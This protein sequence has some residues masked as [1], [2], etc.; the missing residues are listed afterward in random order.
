MDIKATKL[1]I[2]KAIAEIESEVLI[3]QILALLPKAKKKRVPNPEKE[4]F[5]AIAREPLPDYISVE[6]LK[7][8]QGYNIEKLNYFYKN[9]N[10]SIWEGENLMD[11]LNDM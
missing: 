2:I 9:T 1:E 6:K 10:R 4:D 8:E 5:L 7:K 3:K 11:I